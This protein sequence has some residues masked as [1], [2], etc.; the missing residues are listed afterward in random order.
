MDIKGI[1]VTWLGH[2]TF[3]CETPEGKTVLVDPWTKSNPFCPP[4]ELAKLGQA[5]QVLAL[6]PGK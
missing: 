6:E 1:G 5:T 3:L 4:E 2:A